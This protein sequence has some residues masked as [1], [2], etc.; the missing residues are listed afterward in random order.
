M[1]GMID[2]VGAFGKAVAPTKLHEAGSIPPPDTTQ[3]PVYNGTKLKM[4]RIE[5]SVTS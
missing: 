2:C 3:G 4:R 5:S 1:A